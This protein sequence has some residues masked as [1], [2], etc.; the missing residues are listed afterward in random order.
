MRLDK[1]ETRDC[2]SSILPDMFL[3]LPLLCWLIGLGVALPSWSHASVEGSTS[4][5]ADRV[6]DVLSPP[7][8]PQGLR[9]PLEEA[10][11]LLGPRSIRLARSEV[12]ADLLM[13]LS[14]TP[15]DEPMTRAM[16]E[17]MEG[18]V[19]PQDFI[20]FLDDVLREEKYAAAGNVVWVT[21]GRARKAGIFL[22]PDEVFT[23]GARLYGEHGFPDTDRP[24]VQSGL[25]PAKDGDPPGPE[26][27]MRF[28]NPA[29]ESERIEALSSAPLSADF[30]SRI[31][32]LMKQLRAQG[33]HVEL[34]STLRSR[35]RGYLMWGAFLLSRS[36]SEA[37]LLQGL[38][39]LEQ[40]NSEWGLSVPIHWRQSGE[41]DL[42]RQR[43]RAMADTYQV[44][45]ATEA[46]AR[47]SDHYSGKAV[48]LVAVGLPRYLVLIAPDGAKHRFD[49]SSPDHSRDLS[50]SPDLI[51]W[52]EEHFG[53]KKLKGD[54]PHWVD[55][56]RE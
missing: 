1:G 10:A 14:R 25:P 32:S 17:A 7:P 27:T 33:A 21:P 6:F 48:D 49:L 12:N 3:I 30:A 37:S 41:A 5:R 19:D 8:W 52:I 39:K 23:G 31:S 28:K 44:V 26:W 13:G 29:T 11:S 22:H 50:L 54:Y 36:T 43:A 34:T 56:L 24:R 51:R 2:I 47:A 15:A 9:T 16:R 40:A 45:F 42:I 55:G 38:D 4:P 53:L 35:E 46:G 20:F 18:A